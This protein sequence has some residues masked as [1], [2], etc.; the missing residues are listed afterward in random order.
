MSECGTETIRFSMKSGIQYTSST[1]MSGLSLNDTSHRT[2]PY[3]LTALEVAPPISGA[4]IIS[5]SPLTSCNIGISTSRIGCA[6]IHVPPNVNS[7]NT[8]S[9]SP[10]RL[11]CT[12]SPDRES[13]LVL[14]LHQL[15]YLGDCPRHRRYRLQPSSS[16]HHY[17]YTA[18]RVGNMDSQADFLSALAGSHTHTRPVPHD[19]A[20]SSSLHSALGP[21]K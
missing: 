2:W 17:R 21:I 5:S 9:P 7:P 10:F 20:S 11:T 12:T 1:L 3:E 6:T 19:D 15:S 16:Q 14:Y 18:T 13:I 4:N 8:K